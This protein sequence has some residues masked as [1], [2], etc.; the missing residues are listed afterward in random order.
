MLELVSGTDQEEPAHRAVLIQRGVRQ[1]GTAAVG[2]QVN[3]RLRIEQVGDRA[4]ELEVIR[5]LVGRVQF[6]SV[7]C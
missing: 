1:F 4:V 3:R 6:T 7:K 2:L 5:G